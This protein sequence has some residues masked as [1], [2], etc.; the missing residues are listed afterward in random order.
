V[1]RHTQD[2]AGHFSEFPLDMDS[3]NQSSQGL[4]NLPGYRFIAAVVCCTVT[5]LCLVTWLEVLYSYQSGDYMT[6]SVNGR[7]ISGYASES[8]VLLAV[9]FKGSQRPTEWS[10]SRIEPYDLRAAADAILAPRMRF[11]SN[12]MVKLMMP[13]SAALPPRYFCSGAGITCALTENRCWVFRLSLSY[14]AAALLAPS[15]LFWRRAWVT[16]H[17]NRKGLCANC[18]YDLRATEHKCPECGQPKV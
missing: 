16:R 9:Y 1:G 4:R 8:D 17:R 7:D 13:S 2:L 5:V 18:G 11:V 6:G 3:G 12:R 10:F 15:V 14:P